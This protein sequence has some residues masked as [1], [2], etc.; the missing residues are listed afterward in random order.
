[1]I[2]AVVSVLV[3]VGPVVLALRMA[4]LWLVRGGEALVGGDV[5]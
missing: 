2:S 3:L 1:M 5:G 4:V